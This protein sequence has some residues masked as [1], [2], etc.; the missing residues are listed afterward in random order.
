MTIMDNVIKNPNMKVISLPKEL[1]DIGYGNGI[2][3]CTEITN[4][5][6]IRKHER[7]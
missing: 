2:E 6:I 5:T 4:R 7:Y 3:N 1:A